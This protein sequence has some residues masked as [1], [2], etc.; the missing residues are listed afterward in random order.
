MCVPYT[1]R[2][3]ICARKQRNQ[4]WGIQFECRHPISW[5][6]TKHE[7]GM[8]TIHYNSSPN[9]LVNWWFQT[10]PPKLSIVQGV[11]KS[12]ISISL[13]ILSWNSVE[14]FFK[15]FQYLHPPRLYQIIVLFAIDRYKIPFFCIQWHPIP[16]VRW[17]N[18]KTGTYFNVLEILAF[19]CTHDLRP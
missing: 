14:L 17:A 2:T 13:D 6:I 11:G 8:S 15:A 16:I 10:F 12:K 4:F 7:N 5:K 1:Y 9:D 3:Y 18:T 19:Q